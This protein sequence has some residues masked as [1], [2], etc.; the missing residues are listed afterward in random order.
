MTDQAAHPV[1]APAARPAPGPAA[2]A[3]VGGAVLGLSIGLG[4]GVL[5]AGGIRARSAAWTDVTMAWVRLPEQ[6]VAGGLPQTFSIP[7]S[8][9]DFGGIAE[10]LPASL[11][12]VPGYIRVDLTAQTGRVGVALA[13]P[14]GGE[15]VSREAIVTPQQGKTSIY[16]HTVP[17]AGPVSLLLRSA[18]NVSTGAAA[19]VTR[20]Q[21]APEAGLDKGQL[22]KINKAGVY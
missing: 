9:Y 1:S 22:D 15:L 14:D 17:G 8:S 19:D 16:L 10:P 7:A 6:T 12:D 2:K 11:T 4:A 3:F 18:D 13:R 5:I 20:V 21:S